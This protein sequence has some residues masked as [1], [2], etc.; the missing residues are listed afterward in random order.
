MRFTLAKLEERSRAR[1]QGYREEV[2]AAA[3]EVGYQI[4]EIADKDYEALAQKY[5]LPNA[6]ELIANVVT[7]V[8][9]AGEKGFDVRSPEEAEAVMKLCVCCPLFVTDSS[10]CGKC[11]CYLSAKI[12]LK[13]WHCPL[14]KW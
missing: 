1:P 2:L 11:G 5:R 12:Q 7:A 4:Y 14:K 3:K 6:L 10:R 13:A 9:E 8:K